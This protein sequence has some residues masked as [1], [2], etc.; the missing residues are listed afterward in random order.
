M[1]SNYIY[2]PVEN[3]CIISTQFFWDNNKQRLLI[4][5]LFPNYIVIN[6]RIIYSI[7]GE[8]R[9]IERVRFFNLLKETCIEMNLPMH[10][11]IETFFN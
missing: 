6:I 3:A 8:P 4:E 5:N 7:V 1:I 11:S 2:T 10:S 9:L